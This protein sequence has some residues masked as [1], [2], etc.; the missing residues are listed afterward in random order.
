MKNTFLNSYIMDKVDV[1]PPLGFESF[2]FPRH[3]YKL[4]N[5]LYALKQLQERFIADSDFPF[6]LILLRFC[7][8]FHI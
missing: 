2:D 5:A 3:V 7:F 8:Y 4:K 1:E 6:F